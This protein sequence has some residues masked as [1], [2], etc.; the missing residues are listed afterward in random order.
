MVL[1]RS[2]TAR[3]DSDGSEYVTSLK[4]A[5]GWQEGEIVKGGYQLSTHWVQLNRKYGVLNDTQQAPEQFSNLHLQNTR[6]P[7][8]F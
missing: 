4:R 5:A 6:N 7:S 3:S 1:F 2:A 8:T